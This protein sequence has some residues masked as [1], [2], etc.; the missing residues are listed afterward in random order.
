MYIFLLVM[1]ISVSCMIIIR[2]FMKDNEHDLEIK[3]GRF[4]L[5][6]KKHDKE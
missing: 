2:M 1:T 3:A 6:I 4:K 5:S